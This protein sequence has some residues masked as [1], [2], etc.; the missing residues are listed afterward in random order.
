[1]ELLKRCNYGICNYQRKNRFF[2]FLYW[3]RW[4]FNIKLETRTQVNMD[5]PFGG[6]LFSTTLELHPV[7]ES[8]KKER[9]RERR[10]CSLRNVRFFSIIP[11]SVL[12]HEVDGREG[13]EGKSVMNP[14]VSIPWHR[15][16]GTFSPAVTVANRI[17]SNRK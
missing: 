13:R 6:T 2:Y 12:R 7:F 10:G 1:M 9:E 11:S 16:K 8:K 14:K 3:V 15:Q 5:P 17:K 4:R